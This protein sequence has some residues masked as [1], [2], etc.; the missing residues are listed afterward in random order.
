MNSLPEDI[1]YNIFNY[2]NTFN[3]I[4]NF[5]YL[6]KTY[7][8][9][10][11]SF[12]DG[13][14]YI[15]NLNED[16]SL[17]YYTSEYE[18]NKKKYVT[19]LIIINSI[20]QIKF[21]DITKLTYI[22]LNSINTF[23]LINDDYLLYNTFLTNCTKVRYLEITGLDFELPNTLDKLECLELYQ[24]NIKKIPKEY[25]CLKYLFALSDFYNEELTYI[26]KNIMMNLEYVNIKHCYLKHD[27]YLNKDKI[28]YALFGLNYKNYHNGRTKN[29]KVYLIDN[30]N[31][32]S[33]ENTISLD[34]TYLEY[35]T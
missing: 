7:N 21:L 32:I 30:T 31:I 24:C 33:L 35:F 9:L 25:K 20:E 1:I 3:D 15:Q 28:K 22:N 14:I 26:P 19:N 16:Y 18:R 29:I 34:R 6:S 8:N 23:E 11:E 4:I 2:M 27:I 17:V 13:I 10:F 12:Y 5:K